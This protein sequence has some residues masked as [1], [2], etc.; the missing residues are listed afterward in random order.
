MF[1]SPSIGTSLFWGEI[2]IFLG[3]DLFWENKTIF[4][5][6]AIGGGKEAC[7]RGKT[8]WNA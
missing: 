6:C 8:M 2:T 4:G 1:L 5:A 3:T 7:V